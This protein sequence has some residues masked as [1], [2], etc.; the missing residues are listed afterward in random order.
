MRIVVALGGNAILKRGERGTIAEQRATIALACDGIA[1][2]A[3]GN[4]LIVTHGNGPQVGRQILA[5]EALAERE[6]RYPLDVHVAATQGQ[7]G[8]LLQQQ[9]SAALRRAR[10]P[11]PVVTLVTQV[12]VDRDDPAFATPSKPVGPYLSAKGAAE[13]RARGIQI[14]EASGGGWRRVVASPRPIDVVESSSIE[15]QVQAG[16]VPI[17]AGGGGVPVVA[18]PDG[19]EG[20][21]AVI[22]KDATAAV[23]TTA[24]GADLLIVLTDVDGVMSNFGNDDA[25]RIEHLSVADARAGVDDGTFPHGSMAEKVLACAAVAEAGARAVITSLA[26]VRAARDGQAGTRFGRW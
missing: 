13:Y 19:L 22:D 21:P 9:L 18:S 2:I 5:D 3:D 1:S 26:H 12:V 17:V 24:L 4:E 16:A 6:P 14:D 10:A 25:E 15:V 7:I 20:V 23:L 11:R 8:Y